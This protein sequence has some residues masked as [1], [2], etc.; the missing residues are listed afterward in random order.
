MMK[1]AFNIVPVGFSRRKYTLYPVKK[2]LGEPRAALD[3]LDLA[4]ATKFTCLRAFNLVAK[5]F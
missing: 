3:G 4:Y 2:R 1:G 5:D